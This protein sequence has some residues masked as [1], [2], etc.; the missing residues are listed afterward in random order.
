[1]LEMNSQL[2][3]KDS[4]LLCDGIL[5]PLLLLSKAAS[6]YHLAYYID[7]WGP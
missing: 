3:L 2:V 1:M 4:D 6:S 7:Q 5:P